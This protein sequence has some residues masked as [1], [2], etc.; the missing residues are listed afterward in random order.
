MKNH[1]KLFLILSFLTIN[2]IQAQENSTSL[3]LPQ[4]QVYKIQ[5]RSNDRQYDLFIKVPANYAKQ[6]DEQYPVLYYTDGPWHV[7]MVSGITEYM[8][9]DLIL[10][11]IS[12][13]TDMDDKMIEE[14]GPYVSRF[15][16]YSIT[17]SDKPEKQAKYQFGQANDHLKFIRKDVIEFVENNFR[18]DPNNS[19]YFGYSLGGLF[20]AYI[21][22]SQ[23]ESFDNYILG[24]PSLWQKDIPSLTELNPDG[25]LNAKVFISCGSME[26]KLGKQVDEFI[27]MLQA[28]NDQNLSLTHE[29]IEG[30]HQTASPLTVVRGVRWLS[31]NTNFSDMK[32][33]YFG[34]K[35]PGLIPEIFAS[36][37][38]SVKHRD[39]NGFFSNDMKEFYFVRNN[40][41]KDTWTLI[42]YKFSEQGWQESIVGPR[43]GRPLMAPNNEIMHLGGKYVERTKTG[44]SEVKSLGPLIDRKDWGI[45]RLTSSLKGTYVFD[46]YKNGDVI[47]IS[48]IKDGKRQKPIKMGPEIQNGEYSAHPFIAPDE[49]YLIWDCEKESGYGDIDLYISFRQE[50]GSWCEAINMGAEINTSAGDAGGYVTPDG[51][52][53]FFNRSRPEEDKNLAKAGI[54]WVDAKIIDELRP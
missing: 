39:R 6:K 22:M 9:E 52:Y 25:E 43:I 53:F 34:Q 3:E 1:Y 31:L 16:D 32:S 54:Y 17:E 23:P 26:D 27:A 13:Q 21:L 35:V 29:I 38:L 40:E 8:M 7:E 41:Q 4:T 37:I 24:S 47:R 14:V 15:R 48:K 20:G 5:D 42:K 45:M 11:G 49:S 30:T 18:A 36:N 2:S 51:K 46:D 10:V 19:T 44:W 50:N 12:W 28:K 33:P